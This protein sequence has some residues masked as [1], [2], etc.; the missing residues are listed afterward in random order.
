M[1]SQP[2]R[3]ERPGAEQ[4]PW[5]ERPPALLE[6]IEICRRVAAYKQQSQRALVASG[7]RKE[8]HP[9]EMRDAFILSHLADQLWLK[10]KK[11]LPP[12]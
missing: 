2:E 1:A 5:E 11:R 12:D 4:R 3:T 10:L 9:Q 6:A 7:A 8:P